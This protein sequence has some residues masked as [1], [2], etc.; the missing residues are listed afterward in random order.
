[1]NLIVWA[2]M[3]MWRKKLFAF[4]LALS[5]RLGSEFSVKAQIA[6]TEIGYASFL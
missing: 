4:L 1:M 2:Q 5:L 6:D 3:G